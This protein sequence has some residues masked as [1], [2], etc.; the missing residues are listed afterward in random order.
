MGMPQS[1]R[2]SQRMAHFSLLICAFAC[3]CTLQSSAVLT[4]G[5]GDVLTITSFSALDKTMLQA[6]ST[7]AAAAG[8]STA[9]AGAATTAAAAGAATTVGAVATVE[10]GNGTD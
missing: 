10:G 1:L 7:A 4:A 2:Q 5:R 6:T 9:A 3:A 8:A